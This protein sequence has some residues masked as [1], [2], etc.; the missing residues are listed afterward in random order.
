[1]HTRLEREAEAARRL[2]MY[3]EKEAATEQGP[4]EAILTKR[5]Q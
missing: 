1:M 5:Q 3:P 2:D 4:P